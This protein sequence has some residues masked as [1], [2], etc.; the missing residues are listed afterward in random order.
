VPIGDEPIALVFELRPRSCHS[1][2]FKAFI[3]FF[4]CGVLNAID[5]LITVFYTL[6]TGSARDQL[7]WIVES[8]P[9]II[10]WRIV[11]DG[12]LEQLI[13]LESYL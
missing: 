6:R 7:K 5:L 2:I 13:K 4:C 9:S 3:L 1:P 8:S 10:V 12:S 11:L